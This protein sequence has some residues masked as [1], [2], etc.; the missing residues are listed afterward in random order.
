MLSYRPLALSLA[1]RYSAGRTHDPDLEQVACEGLVK[2]IQRFDPEHGAS[3]TSFALPTILG[4]IRRYVRNS[5]WSAHVPR[6]LQERTLTLT[7]ARDCLEAER[8]R[9]LSVADLAATLGWAEEEVAETLCAG[10]ARSAV[11]FDPH[12]DADDDASPSARLGAV[13]PGFDR[14]DC[15]SAIAGALPAL[16]PEEQE[17]IRL[18][19]GGDFT[20]SQIAK[21]MGCSRSQ[22]GRLLDSGLDR[23]R[24]EAA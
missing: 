6:R 10:A 22:V 11:S 8:G 17:V 5:A 1:R 24:V 23:L 15:V 4:E 9:P 7:R 2:A 20:Q 18:R 21:W 16:A 19:F 3:F 12:G 14:V 13:D